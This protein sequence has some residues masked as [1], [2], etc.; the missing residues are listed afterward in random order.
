L[1]EADAA[2]VR[3]EDTVIPPP[4]RPEAE[5]DLQPPAATAALPELPADDDVPAEI[6]EFFVPE[7]EEHLQIAQE[8]LLAMEAAHSPEDINRLFRALHTIKGAAAQVGLH[9]I[10]HVA[11][12]AEDL[13]GKI[14]DGE[15]KP[16]P[17]IVDLCAEL[18]DA[19]RKLLHREWEDESTLQ[20]A[21]RPLLG[22]LTTYVPSE[23]AAV[24][25]EPEKSSR[26]ASAG[27][28][29]VHDSATHEP[30]AELHG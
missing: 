19:I 23:A 24:T 15:L 4:P 22:R 25:P 13:I 14:R 3:R 7:A 1:F 27:V 10:S 26:E 11:H 9:R 6:L 16:K 17:A 18:V 2:P 21:V 8:C 5:A 20:Q 12:A 30:V 28:T 29:E